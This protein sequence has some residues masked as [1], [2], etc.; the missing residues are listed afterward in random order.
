MG[1]PEF[2]VP[3]LETLIKSEF[4]EITAVICNPD[5]L[6]GRKQI[7]TPPPTKILAQKYNIPIFQP[8]KIREPEWI[9][10]IKELNPELIVVAAFGQIIPGAILDIPKYS[11][12]NVHGSLLPKL[13][14]ASPIQYAI[15]EG[16]EKTG[17]TIMLMDEQMDHGWILDQ[18][19]IDIA[20]KETYSTLSKKMS[21]ISAPFL[22]ETLKLWINGKI[23]PREQ[24][25][26]E[27]TYTKIIKKEDGK[28]NWSDSAEKI[29]R[30]IRAFDPWP[31]AFCFFQ[32]Q[33]ENQKRLKII[34]ADVVICDDLSLRG[35]TSR[36][37]SLP[38]RTV[39]AIPPGLLFENNHNILIQTGKNCLKLLK[40]Q[41][42]G[43]KPMSAREFINGY[44][45]LLNK[46]LK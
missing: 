19:E 20:P 5:K 27:A 36:D 23:K 39:S 38:L 9:K 33:D 24:N 1:T 3:I 14:G 16:L 45:H 2:A 30:Q 21:K 28:I 42:E 17:A 43:K 8:N 10:K 32:D 4:L 44:S 46:Q 25:H 35:A 15:L 41:P 26:N 31:G 34:G 18:K 6:I 22:L 7:L 37:P 12:I 11:A 40:V 29:E 13:R